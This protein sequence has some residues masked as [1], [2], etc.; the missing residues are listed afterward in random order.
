M[1]NILKLKNNFF[2]IIMLVVALHSS[3]QDARFTQVLSNPLT[4]NP[5]MMGLNSD[6]SFTGQ[7]RDQWGSINSGY[8]TFA[9]TALAPAYRK[10]NGTDKLDFGFNAI[11]DVAGAY[12]S[13]NLSLAAGYNLKISE[14]SFLNVSFMGGMVQRTLD[15]NKLTFDQQYVLG[16][17]NANNPNNET[18]LNKKITFAD[19]SVGALWYSAPTKINL[20][21][22]RTVSGY[23]GASV[24]HL[25]TPPNESFAGGT[26]SLPM[27]FSYQA[28]I[29]FIGDKID[30][31]PNA[32]IN[33]QK[34]NN[35][36]AAGLLLDY[37]FDA[38]NKLSLGI[39]IRDKD[40]V[41]FCAGYTWLNYRL[42]Y[43]YDVSSPSTISNA[44]SALGAHE[45]TFCV[46]FDRAKERRVTVVP[47]FL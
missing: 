38:I 46:R 8:R 20:G 19:I 13:L 45:L 36:M 27:R 33:Y 25:N 40:A 31:S 35:N 42:M 29:K 30:V 24:F 11:S 22:E 34:G 4:L 7:I 15:L 26:A 10:T 12:N 37:R 17:Y 28:G 44:A 6:L 14:S 39:W 21:K 23:A 16:T 43:S 9:F 3:A 32:Y 47:S 1:K 5:A 41:A 2:T 18:T